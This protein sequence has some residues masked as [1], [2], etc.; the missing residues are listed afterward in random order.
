[1]SK[2]K[3]FSI[4]LFT[5]IIICLIPILSIYLNIEWPAIPLLDIE[6]VFVYMLIAPFLTNFILYLKYR[7]LSFFIF[8]NVLLYSIFGVW[9]FYIYSYI[10][11]HFRPF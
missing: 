4:S 1:M 11:E 2:I 7:N 8:F 6:P 5:N 10:L 9:L 3:L